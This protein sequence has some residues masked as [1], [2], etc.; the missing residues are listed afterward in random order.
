MSPIALGFMLVVPAPE[1]GT[2]LISFPGV[3]IIMLPFSTEGIP[4]VG[5][6]DAEA[7]TPHAAEFGLLLG[8]AIRFATA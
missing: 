6:I 8:G 4:G 5:I 3:G 7:F 2:T 1:V